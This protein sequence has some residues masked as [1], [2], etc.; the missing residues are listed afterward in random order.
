MQD[1]V[2]VAP[3]A[4]TQALRAALPGAAHLLGGE[5]DPLEPV[6]AHRLQGAIDGRA[7]LLGLLL[8]DR[9]QQLERAA[10]VTR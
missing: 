5:G 2:E 7:R 10:P 4:L 9:L 6:G 1:V 3:Q 8:A